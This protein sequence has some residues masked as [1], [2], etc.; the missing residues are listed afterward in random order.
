[1]S[2]QLEA[3]GEL[4]DGVDRYSRF[5]AEELLVDERGLDRPLPQGHRPDPGRI[6][7]E[8]VAV[9]VAFE[10]DPQR[11]V[12]VGPVSAINSGAQPNRLLGL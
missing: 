10:H 8:A 12:L 5:R 9:A 11:P 6:D 2:I 3:H 1:M 7:H 4:V